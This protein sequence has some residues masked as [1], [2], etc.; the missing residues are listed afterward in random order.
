MVDSDGGRIPTMMDVAKAAG[1]S[2]ALVSIVMRGAPGASDQ[3]RAHVL[4]AAANLGY[5]PDARAQA[6]RQR[7]KPS[8]GVVFQ[9]SQ[10]FQAAI[11]DR[12]YAATRDTDYS[13]V[14]SATT[15]THGQS[16]ALESLIGYRCGSLIALGTDLTAER[17][18]PI[19]KRL[20]LI[21][22]AWLLEAEGVEC[23]A[24]DDDGG[25]T[26]AVGHLV[27]LGHRRITFLE[28]PSAGGNAERLRGYLTA[29]A[30]HGLEEEIDVVPA[31]SLEEGGAMAAAI[32]LERPELPTAIIG[33]NDNCAAG[34]QDL[35]VRK[36]VR[37]PEDVSL[38]GFD[39]SEIAQV[40]YRQLT[41]VRQDID[42]LAH[43]A[44]NR[45]I[46]RMFGRPGDGPPPVIP[47]SLTLR[48]TTAPPRAT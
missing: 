31:G 20:P 5:V 16:A 27:S 26:Q 24:S 13:V 47:T 33:F 32:L 29:M 10:A 4:A 7:G 9:P 14:L 28:S 34:V 38:V 37:I 35:F 30:A 39:D 6:L 45:A 1:V 22:V 43:V 8:I 12:I 48:R 2:R 3:T 36:G 23:V 21:V 15:E 18:A 41:T 44:V 19:A 11:V 17:L 42:A 40:S 25:L 46:D